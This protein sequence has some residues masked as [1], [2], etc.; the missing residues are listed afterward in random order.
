MMD[1]AM[2]N[3]AVL[4]ATGSIG[5][6]ALDVIA[7]HPQRLR[8]SVLAAGCNVAALV[9]LCRRH[10]PDHAVVADETCFDAL[11]DGL[12]AAGLATQAHAGKD[13]I[14]TLA[15]DA[16]CDTVVAAIVGAA[17]LDSALAAARATASTLRS[18]RAC[19][20]GNRE[21]GIGNRKRNAM[22]C[23]GSC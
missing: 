18:S 12:H 6:S 23:G 1:A 8:A 16:A 4:G 19:K 20:C 13:A 11:R 10:R 17:G 7:R 21:S 5:S 14:E 9:E 15:A 2:R 3:V 22:E